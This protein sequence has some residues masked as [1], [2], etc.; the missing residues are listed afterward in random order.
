M[1]ARLSLGFA[2]LNRLC[3]PGIAAAVVNPQLGWVKRWQI[4]DEG[5]QVG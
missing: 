2:G 4:L 3:R 5:M 1:A